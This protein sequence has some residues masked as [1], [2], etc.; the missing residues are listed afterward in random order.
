MERDMLLGEGFW[1]PPQRAFLGVRTS[2][3]MGLK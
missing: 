2:S 3:S 1:R